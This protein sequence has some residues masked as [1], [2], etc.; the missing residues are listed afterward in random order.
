[1]ACNV[2]TFVDDKRVVGPSEE[3]T[4][5]ASHVLA[6]M[7]SYLGIQDAPRKARPCSQIMGAWDGAII[8]VL[9]QLGMCVL[10]SREKWRKM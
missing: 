7:Q 10:T 2:F 8:H 1:M 5:Q 9:D 3:L 4:W 6:S